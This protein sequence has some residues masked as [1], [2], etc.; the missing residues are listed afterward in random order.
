MPRAQGRTGTKPS[1]QLAAIDQMLVAAI[2]QGPAKK[3]EAINRILELVPGWTR[4]D[5]WERIRHLRKTGEFV[6]AA[7][8]HRN[9]AN[10]P[11]TKSPV[12]RRPSTSPSQ[13]WTPAQDDKLF[14]LAGYEPVKKI[15]RR[16]GRSERAVRC[17]LGALGISA[18]VTDGWSLRELR[19]MLRVHQARLTYLIGSGMLRVRDPRIS[20]SSLAALCDKLCASLDP[21]SIE[22][23]AADLAIGDG[24]YPWERAADLLGVPLAQIQAWISAGQLRLVDTFVTD[25]SFEEFC[26]NHGEELKASLIDPPTAKWLASEYG[27]SQVAANGRSVSRARKHALV[28]RTCKCG[29]QIAGNPYFRHLR[30]CPS[31]GAA[32]SGNPSN[33]VGAGG[34]TS[35]SVQSSRSTYKSASLR[36]S[37]NEG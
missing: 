12:R 29:R 14:Q 16:L 22:R 9:E 10:D 30:A 3:R 37:S 36:Q 25:R 13:P 34:R 21:S 2:K 24:A 27:V 11:G 35:T 28:I 33:K 20:A 7:D 32:P 8:G 15:A 31:L 4:E 18:K 5:C 26:K 23:I 1:K 6:G 19:K 17:R